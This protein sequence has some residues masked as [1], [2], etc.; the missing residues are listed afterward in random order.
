MLTAV[1]VKAAD[2]PAQR[3]LGVCG[4][5]PSFLRERLLDADEVGWRG[6]G[7][8]KKGVDRERGIAGVG[9][10]QNIAGGIDRVIAVVGHRQLLAVAP[11]RVGVTRDAPPQQPP[12]SGWKG[13]TGP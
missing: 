10:S 4:L 1:L 5:E 12:L 7:G 9:V 6:I 2:R 8:R 11:A 3:R 13:E